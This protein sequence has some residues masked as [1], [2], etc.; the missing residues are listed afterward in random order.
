MYLVRNRLKLIH[1]WHRNAGAARVLPS[2]HYV[3]PT[4]TRPALPASVTP[5]EKILL[6]T[7]KVHASQIFLSLNPLNTD[8]GIGKWT[9]FLCNIYATVP[10]APNR[11]LL[12]E[13]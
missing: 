4:N 6:D 10:L 5:V 1:R 7:I 9:R 3:Q 8:Y 12:Y 11:G 2:R 13:T